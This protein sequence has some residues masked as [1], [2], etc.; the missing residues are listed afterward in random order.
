[1]NRGQ[2]PQQLFFFHRDYLQSLILYP[3]L[4]LP[5][6][7]YKYLEKVYPFLVAGKSIIPLISP[8]HLKE[9]ATIGRRK[10]VIQ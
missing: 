6:T 10:N 3:S 7:G 1:M 5:A 9:L 2:L 4:K 8:Y